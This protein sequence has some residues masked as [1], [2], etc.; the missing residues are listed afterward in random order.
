MLQIGILFDIDELGGGWYGYASY[1]IFFGALDTGLLLGCS[2]R[3][4]DTNETLQGS[5]RQCCISVEF[6]DESKVD[7]LKNALSNSTA[8]GLLPLHPVFSKT[9]WCVKSLWC[10]R[11]VSVLPESLLIVRR[12]G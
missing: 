3:D 6:P 8:K 11:A 5:A 12:P 9:L 1:K 10:S 7:A 4:G 2:L